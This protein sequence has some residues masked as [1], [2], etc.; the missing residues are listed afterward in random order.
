MADVFEDRRDFDEHRKRL[1]QIIA[2]TPHLDWLLLTK[3]PQNVACLVP[4]TERWPENVWLG[5]TAENQRWLDKRMPA[6]ASLGARI[7]FLSC[8]PLLGPLD[9]SRW[10]EGANRRE[11]RYYGV[12]PGGG[13]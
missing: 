12:P 6:L 2:D 1:W 4:W 8:E 5:A 9:L 3:R 7:L 13:I 11:H 10:I